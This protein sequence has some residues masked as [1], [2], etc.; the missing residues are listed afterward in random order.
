MHTKRKRRVIP[1]QRRARY[2]HCVLFVIQVCARLTLFPIGIIILIYGS[3]AD[4]KGDDQEQ[5]K[6]LKYIKRT[7]FIIGAC[8]LV[9]S[10]LA[11]VNTYCFMTLL[12]NPTSNIPG[13]SWIRS[14]FRN[15]LIRSSRRHAGARNR[16]AKRK[17]R[18]RQRNRPVSRS[19]LDSKDV[20]IPDSS[21]HRVITHIGSC[22][23]ESL[24]LRPVEPISSSS[25]ST[26]VD[27]GSHENDMVTHVGSNSPQDISIKLAGSRD[28]WK[29]DL[30]LEPPVSRRMLMSSGASIASSETGSNA[31]IASSNL[32]GSKSSSSSSSKVTFI[33]SCG[34]STISLPSAD[35]PSMVQ[36]APSLSGN[37][38]VSEESVTGSRGSLLTGR[39]TRGSLFTGPS[40]RDS[41]LTGRTTRSVT[42]IGSAGDKEASLR[43]S[44]SV[45]FDRE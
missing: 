10:C 17:I 1:V 30:A 35:I 4:Y 14:K 29:T 13:I 32:G 7:L 38:K 39:T 21:L 44:S 26:S 43:G 27:V 15:E 9:F 23:R 8:I 33:G 34:Q 20:V 3:I 11:M 45:R 19:G 28:R 16:R 36:G 24:S 37:T 5:K 42:H 41:V 40:T 6:L 2:W 25:T 18:K 22:G 12:L 31:S